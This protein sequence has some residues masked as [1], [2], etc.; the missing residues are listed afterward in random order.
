MST[1]STS[2]FDPYT[3]NVTILAADGVTPVIISLPDIDSFFYYNTASCINLGAQLGASLVM[4]FV[5]IVLTK[6]SKRRTPIYILNLFSLIFSFLRSL[7]LALYFVSPWSETYRALALDFSTVPRSAYATSIAGDVIPLCMTLTI[8]ISLVLQAYTVCKNMDGIY[9]CLI[10]GMSCV[11]FLLAVGFRFGQAVTN[12]ILIIDAATNYSYL[13]IET[14]T[15]AT[16]TI[17]IWWFSIIFTSKLLYV[18]YIRRRNHWK[19]W[20]NVTIL[21]AMGGCTMI[22]PCKHSSSSLEVV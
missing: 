11:V 14:G 20:S 15:L 2:A 6:P 4:F 10:T 7:L 8:N 5:V 13:W 9:R 17:S 19:Q 3:Q 21:A 1:T 16:E 18:L 12:S 22:I